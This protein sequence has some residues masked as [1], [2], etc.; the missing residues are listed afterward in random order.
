[1]LR[2]KTR[3]N[4]FDIEMQRNEVDTDELLVFAEDEKSFFFS[5]FLPRC[6]CM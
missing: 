3:W 5:C 1:M 6:Y 4:F 2:K